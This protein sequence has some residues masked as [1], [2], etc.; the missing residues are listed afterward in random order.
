[1]FTI[2]FNFDETTKKVTN[3]K[4]VSVDVSLP[5][6][7]NYIVKYVNHKKFGKG[8]IVSKKGNILIVDFTESGK[9]LSKMELDIDF[10]IQN[11]LIEI[12]D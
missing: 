2:S 3:L 1:M 5:T 4:V 11:D 6:N 9:G 10:C 7:E 8:V 12:L